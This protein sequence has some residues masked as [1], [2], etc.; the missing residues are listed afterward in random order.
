MAKQ[1]LCTTTEPVV[2]TRAGKLRGFMLDGIYTFHGIKY[3][4]AER[5]G[6]P[7]PVA[8]WEGLKDALSYGYIAPLLEYP[9]P[10]G[11]VMIPHRFWPEHE[12]C[13]YLNVWTLHLDKAAKRPV[14]VWLHGGGFSAG[15]A[16]EQVAYEG[17]NL[18]KYGDVVVVSLNHRLNLLGYLDLSSYGEKY[19]NSGNAGMADIVAALQWV[20]DN[21]AAFGGDPD[22]VTVFGQSG[23][24][25]KVTALGQIAE[26]EGLYHKGIVMSGVAD[27]MMFG[28]KQDHR[29]IVKA[30]LE[31]FN[32]RETEVEKLET[33]PVTALVKA[34]NRANKKLL[35]Q[36]IFVN[37]GPIDNDWYAGDPLTKGF[38]GAAKKIPLMAGTVI[39][40]FAFGPAIPG[41]QG[42]SVADRR[43]AVAARF[44][45][46]TDELISLF[47]KAYPGKNETDL[48]SLDSFFRPGTL[49]YI[50]KKSAEGSA[51]VY[52]Y[53]FALE[54]DYDGGKPAW[55]CSDIPFVFHN[56][57]RIAVCNIPGVTE[58][59]E[60]E[61]AGAY[62]SFASCGNPSHPALPEWPAYTPDK[63]AT[64]V[65]DR[66]SEVRFDYEREL[67]ALL[68]KASPPFDFASLMQQQ[69]GEEEDAEKAWLY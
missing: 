33:I 19:K 68:A 25:M 66:K 41:R 34:F 47:N 17:D 32:L 43:K 23:G 51:P 3:A 12:K 6:P 64:M 69:A 54:F 59:L 48:L 55:H 9:A 46:Y 14:M 49:K 40:E 28:G 11:E 4:E 36:G 45:D 7:K 60:E 62:V 37:W 18:C 52:S 53:M 58:K 20:Q 50:E 42:L 26:A 8:P 2:E 63:K 56:T 61:M 21:I 30:L 38:T 27:S 57:G 31:E 10:Q 5:F 29:Q 35:K 13:N 67:L 39:A 22:N 15:S 44:G 1:F 65:F 16:I 24:G